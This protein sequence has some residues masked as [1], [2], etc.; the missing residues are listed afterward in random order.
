MIKN[1]FDN[2]KFEQRST[3]YKAAE[4]TLSV[5]EKQTKVIFSIDDKE[6][7]YVEIYRGPNYIVGASEPN[8]SRCYKNNA[9]NKVPEDYRHIVTKLVEA[10]NNYEWKK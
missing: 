6:D 4:I 9:I 1:T 2:I 7:V 3:G 8:W 5:Y 10:H